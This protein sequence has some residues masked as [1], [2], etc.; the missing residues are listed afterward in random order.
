[1]GSPRAVGGPRPISSSSSDGD[2]P[3][4][5]SPT[6]PLRGPSHNR[7]THGYWS[8]DPAMYS[9]F[10]LDAPDSPLKGNLGV[11]DIGDLA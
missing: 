2:T 8:D 11:I 1:M 4:S 6:G 5:A 3:A 9:T 10:I 7:G